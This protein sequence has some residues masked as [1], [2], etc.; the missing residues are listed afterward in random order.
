MT[1]FLMG[2]PKIPISMRLRPLEF[3]SG[4][5]ILLEKEK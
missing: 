2:V 5:H 1:G 3:Y 4:K